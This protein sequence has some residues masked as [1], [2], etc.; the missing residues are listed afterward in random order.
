MECWRSCLQSHYCHFIAVCMTYYVGFPHFSLLSLGVTRPL[1]LFT[2]QLLQQGNTTF[3]AM[4][5]ILKKIICITIGTGSLTGT[6]I[7]FQSLIYVTEYTNPS[8]HWDSE[9]CTG[10]ETIHALLPNPNGHH[11]KGLCKL[12]ACPNQHSDGAWL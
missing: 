1:P 4:K 11:W 7:L 10:Y 6:W 3:K 12:D 8:C 9:L 5:E 2:W